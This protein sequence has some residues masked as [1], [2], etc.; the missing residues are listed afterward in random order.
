MRNRVT[1][2]DVRYVIMPLIAVVAVALAGATT[3]AITAPQSYQLTSTSPPPAPP[4][5]LT[6]NDQGYVRVTTASNAIGCSINAELVA[7]QTSSDSWPINPAGR[8][9][10]TV[11]ISADGK[12]QFVDADLGA[13]AGK[14]ELRPGKYEAQGWAVT[15]IADTVSFTNDR[16]GHGMQVD[17]RSVRPF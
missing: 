9:F 2:R 17:T 16:T 6:A 12:F 11:S 4:S 5:S 13:L 8:P 3:M 10:H 15:A 1:A 7:C 14:F